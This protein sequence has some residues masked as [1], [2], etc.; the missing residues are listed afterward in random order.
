MTGER[1]MHRQTFQSTSADQCRPPAGWHLIGSIIRL[2]VFRYT[3]RE[4]QYHSS[5]K[6]NINTKPATN[7]KGYFKWNTLIQVKTLDQI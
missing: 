6:N 5:I 3:D 7:K 1:N 2:V 4:L